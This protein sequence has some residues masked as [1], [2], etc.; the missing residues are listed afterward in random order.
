[1]EH[2]PNAGKLQDQEKLINVAHLTSAFYRYIPDTNIPNQKVSFGTSGH[3]GN[4]L[5]T[6]FNELHIASICQALAEYRATNHITGPCFVGKDTHALSE[7]ALITAIEVLT[8]NSVDVVIQENN[9]FTPTPV[10]SRAIIRHNAIV[11]NCDQQADGIVITPSHNPPTDGGFKY[12]ETHGGP[13][14]GQTTSWIENRANEL[15]AEG[16]AKIVRMPIKEAMASTYVWEYT[17]VS[18]CSR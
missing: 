5:E 10:I 13:A 3:R 1:M 11:G 7:P 8:A 12:N 9:G 17:T 2:H 14:A 18:N 6:T 15:M 16:F 4:A